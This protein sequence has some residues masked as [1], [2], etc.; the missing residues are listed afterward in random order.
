VSDKLKPWFDA[1][2]GATGRQL[3]D[4][5]LAACPEV[6][7]DHRVRTV[8]RGLKTWRRESARALVLGKSDAVTAGGELSGGALRGLRASRPAGKLPAPA[9]QTVET[10][11]IAP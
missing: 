4:R 11:E 2:P 7:P 9:I 10:T 3:L 6:H 1:D 8:Q 5:L